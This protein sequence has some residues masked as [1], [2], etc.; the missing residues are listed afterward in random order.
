M[1]TVKA[2]APATISNLACGFDMLGMAVSGMGDYVLARKSNREGIFID[3]IIGPGARRLSKIDNTALAGVLSLLK[4]IP[5]P[6]F[7]ISL[8]IQKGYH[9]GSGLGSSA[10]SS[11]AAVMAVHRLLGKPFNTKRELFDYCYEGE[12]SVDG[13]LPSD[14][15]AASLLGGLILSYFN[16][17]PLRLPIPPGLGIVVIQP[18]NHDLSVLTSD[19][20][21]S[22]P[23]K[24]LLQE[25]TQQSYKLAQLI[26]GL[27][28]SDFP[29]IE[30]GLTDLII[31]PHRSEH[32]AWFEPL[33]SLSMTHEALGFSI[34]G[35]GPA[36]WGLFPNTFLA[37]R[38]CDE[39]QSGFPQLKFLSTTI[40]LEGA[41]I[42]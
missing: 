7:G 37:D 36:L 38:F 4:D 8:E 3:K 11:V 40:D 26:Q 17:P 18:M 29:T 20:R 34:S 35:S 27:Y 9:F 2:F 25:H 10:A 39:A 28:R 5:P 41:Y 22:L 23:E 31:E 19:E 6:D 30:Q 14:N 12:R 21:S 24:I 33:Q 32:I 15:T 42:C 1:D 13:S 16:E